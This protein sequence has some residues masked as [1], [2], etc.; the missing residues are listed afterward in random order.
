MSTS[1]PSFKDYSFAHYGEVYKILKEVFT[2]H[3]IKYYLIGANARDIAL[4]QA[5][6]RPTRAT[7]DIDFA[8]MVPD[9]S[10][11]EAIKTDL[12]KHGFEDTNGAMPYRMFHPKSKTVIDLLPFGGIE[13]NKMVSF[14]NGKI[15]LSTV[16]M[17]Q[18]AEEIEMFE[19]PE[20]FSIPFSPAHGLVILKLIAWSEKQEIREKDLGDTANLL[21]IA[22]A[23]YEPELYKENAEHADLFELQDFETRI[24]AARIMGRKMQRILKLDQDLDNKIKKLLQDELDA[25][26]G[27]LTLALV[28]ALG[29]DLD[30]AKT[31]IRTVQRGIMESE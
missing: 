14:L 24:V 23:L 27:S 7:A 29:T 13:E 5:G 4:Y 1:N 15:E 31:I 30:F 8:V 12:R 25:N 9:H 20:G 22:W 10:H 18:V 17:E 21:R 6:E 16:G 26:T 11:Y 19:H 2:E 3:G 28:K